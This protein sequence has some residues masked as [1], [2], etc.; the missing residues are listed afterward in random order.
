MYKYC[1]VIRR[2]FEYWVILNTSL[3][4]LPKDWRPTDYSGSW[5]QEI[6]VLVSFQTIV[7]IHSFHTFHSE[8]GLTSLVMLD[9][10]NKQVF[11][12]QFISHT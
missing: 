11:E 8:S 12:L 5:K 1:K 2:N 4:S 3:K 10:Q 6:G 9:E 7:R